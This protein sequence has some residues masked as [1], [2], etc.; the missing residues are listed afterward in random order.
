MRDEG[1]L[2]SD[3]PFGGMQMIVQIFLII[4]L[5]LSA[6]LILDGFVDEFVNE[7]RKLN[8]VVRVATAFLMAMG[9]G[10]LLVRREKVFKRISCW[11]RR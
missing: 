11:F 5:A 8:G 6:W 2:I 10:I 3:A 1:P 9:C 7:S 4:Y